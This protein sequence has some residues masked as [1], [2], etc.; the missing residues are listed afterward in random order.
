MIEQELKDILVK[1]FD[2]RIIDVINESDLHSGHASSPGT[3]QS[4]F[5][6]SIVSNDFRGMS[7]IQRHQAVNKVVS[8]LFDKGLHA[9]SLDLNSIS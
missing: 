4:H 5:R 1:K 6:V 9:L 7:R 3:G 2:C 8:H